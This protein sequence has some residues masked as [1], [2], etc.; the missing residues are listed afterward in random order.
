MTDTDACNHGGDLGDFVEV[1]FV[2]L[3]FKFEDFFLESDVKIFVI[4][5]G[6]VDIF[7]LKDDLIG[8]G[9]FVGLE[10]ASEKLFG[11]FLDSEVGHDE[12]KKKCSLECAREVHDSRKYKQGRYR[13]IPETVKVHNATGDIKE[14]EQ[15]RVNNNKV[16]N[17]LILKVDSLDKTVIDRHVFF[18]IVVGVKCEPQTADILEREEH[19]E[20]PLYR[21]VPEVGEA[22]EAELVEGESV[23]ELDEDDP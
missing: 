9:L 19:E 11:F 5:F 10:E 12:I 22:A 1:D 14:H 21:A 16:R 3:F 6:K 15:Y 2:L 20:E 8:I 18:K 7:D 23:V 13:R 4:G 17:G